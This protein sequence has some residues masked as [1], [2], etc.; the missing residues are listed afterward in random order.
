M[1]AAET[2]VSLA[3]LVPRSITDPHLNPCLDVVV[4]DTTESR[5]T[6]QRMRHIHPASAPESTGT[7]G[8]GVAVLWIQPLCRRDEPQASSKAVEP[9]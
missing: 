8:T 6:W 5:M 9:R 2:S 4:P 3:I 1:E 7:R